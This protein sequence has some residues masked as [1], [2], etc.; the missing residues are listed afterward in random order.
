MTLQVTAWLKLPE[1]DAVNVKVSF[2]P[3]VHVGSESATRIPESRVTVAVATALVLSTWAE[4]VMFG[5]AVAVPPVPLGEVRQGWQFAR[6][7]C[8]C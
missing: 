4:M 7:N 3:I 6:R 8:R 2:V 5:M 1:T